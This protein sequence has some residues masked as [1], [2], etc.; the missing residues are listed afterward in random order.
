MAEL[1]PRS[2]RID[3]ETAEKFKKIC[4]EA[5]LNQQDALAKLIESYELQA[6]KAVLTEKRDEIEQFERYTSILIQK[7]MVALEDYQNVKQTVRTEFN[8]LIHSKNGLIEDL[9]QQKKAAEEAMKQA[10]AEAMKASQEA[11]QL[12]E[13]LEAAQKRCKELEADKE[14]FTGRN[15]DLEA[16]RKR[17]EAEVTALKED[18][19]T[20]EALR[21]ELEA[22][23]AAKEA[24]ES[25]LASEK[26]RLEFEQ[27]EALLEAEQKHQAE[28]DKLKEEK[29]Q[30]IDDYQK[31]Y[32]ELLEKLQDRNPEAEG[33]KK[34]LE[35]T[36][37]EIEAF[38]KDAKSNHI[39][40]WYNC[41]LFTGEVDYCEG[42]LGHLVDAGCVLALLG[43]KM[44]ISVDLSDAI[45]TF[46]YSEEGDTLKIADAIGNAIIIEK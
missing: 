16:D 29:R 5:G 32:L 11:D 8:A 46:N 19:K 41:K 12:R 24:A 26:K 22:V 36:I 34:M 35:E 14:T 23:K 30:A 21:K 37:D 44:G 39:N 31:K 15:K 17:L 33:G 9:Q 25:N 10:T 27:K 1:R 20:M 2:F 4:L 7:Y 28:I 40:I 43:Q 38:L 18:Q 42:E 3:E 13:Q 45:A 6:G